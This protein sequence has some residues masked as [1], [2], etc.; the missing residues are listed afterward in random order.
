MSWLPYCEQ[1]QGKK[2]EPEG[3]W[4]KPSSFVPWSDA[5]YQDGEELK[6]A[7]M[8]NTCLY[9]DNINLTFSFPVPGTLF[10]QTRASKLLQKKQCEPSKHDE[11]K[12]DGS[13]WQMESE[14]S[15]EDYYFADIERFTLLVDHAYRVKMPMTG[16]VKIGSAGQ[17]DGCAKAEY[18]EECNP[19]GHRP[20]KNGL[21]P[22]IFQLGGLGNIVSLGDLLRL[23]H[24]RGE[25]ILDDIHPKHKDTLRWNGGVLQ[26]NVEYENEHEFKPLG[27]GEVKYQ[28]SAQL[29]AQSEFKNM[30]GHEEGNQR[31][32]HDTHGFLILANVQGTMYLFDWTYLFQVLTTSVGMMAVA[33]VVVDMFMTTVMSHAKQFSILTTQPSINFD[34]PDNVD[35]ALSMAS[36]AYGRLNQQESAELEE[37]HESTRQDKVHVKLLD[38]MSET[39]TAAAGNSYDDER[40]KLMHILLMFEKRLN[41]LDGLNE[42]FVLGFE[43]DVV[44]GTDKPHAKHDR[45][46]ELAVKHGKPPGE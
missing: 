29:L 22:S 17:Y 16:E 41:T 33:S 31:M 2:K 9:K 32:V 35:R 40:D 21:Y 42:A 1:Y 34:K 23:S 46:R 27:D 25:K 36:K 15:K 3:G 10:L 13:L 26:I 24:K 39:A 45:V 12:C 20:D 14:E 28:L 18:G 7:G 37:V 44:E 38:K 43:E 11:W 6:K 8:Q 4:A 19:I 5:L 30:F